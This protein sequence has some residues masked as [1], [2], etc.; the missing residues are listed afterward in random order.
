MGNYINMNLLDIFSNNNSNISNNTNKEFDEFIKKSFINYI[1]NSSLFEKY[2]KIYENE[3]SFA[4]ECKELYVFSEKFYSH[5]LNKINNPININF[6]DKS[7]LNKSF[8]IFDLNDII[9]DDFLY[10]NL[11]KRP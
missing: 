9:Y 10:N 6:K 11:E 3:S 5:A 2:A 1:Q 8:M 7:Y 4:E